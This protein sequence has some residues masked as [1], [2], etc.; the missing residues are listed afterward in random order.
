MYDT[1]THVKMV[2]K[3]IR[4]MRRRRETRRITA[5]YAAC[6]LLS[7]ALVGAVD[8]FAGPK[9]AALSGMYGSMLLHEGAGGYVLV[10]VLAFSAA[11]VLTVVCIR[12]RGKDRR[13][14]EEQ[15]EKGGDER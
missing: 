7:A 15:A 6:T 14:N 1:A 3:R 13:R 5:L 12:F 8:T 9:Q 4:Q 11:V 2:K 10:G